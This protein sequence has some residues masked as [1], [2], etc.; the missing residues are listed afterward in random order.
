MDLCYS[1]IEPGGYL[2]KAMNNDMV[3]ALRGIR[4]RFSQYGRKLSEKGRGVKMFA[5]RNLDKK[6]KES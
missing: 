5:Q 6:E 1:S 4:S 2:K 3:Q